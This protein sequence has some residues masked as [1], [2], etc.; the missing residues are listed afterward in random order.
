LGRRRNCNEGGL[1]Q[2]MTLRGVGGRQAGPKFES[3]YHSAHS[4]TQPS[5]STCKVNKHSTITEPKF[6][7]TP[8]PTSTASTVLPWSDSSNT[9][10][11]SCSRKS[12]FSMYALFHSVSLCSS[13]S[14]ISGNK[15]PTFVR[16]RSCAGTISRTEKIT[17]SNLSIS[18][19]DH[20]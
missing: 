1:L 4:H 7:C 2:K 6:Y 16:S 8:P 18:F 10:S 15:M 9:T 20:Y 5:V 14:P 19:A 17:T 11:K 13:H 3:G 12:T